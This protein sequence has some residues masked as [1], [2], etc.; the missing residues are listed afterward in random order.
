[1]DRLKQAALITKLLDHLREK[2]YGHTEAHIQIFVFFAQELMGIPFGF[3]FILY[4]GGPFSFDLRDELTSSVADGLIRFVP[5][6]VYRPS[7]IPT[8]LAKKLQNNYSNLF[9]DKIAYITDK[10][11]PK[12][13]ADLKRLA[14]ALFIAKRE[15][16]DK[17]EQIL[18]NDEK[19]NGPL[20][21]FP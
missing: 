21:S 17:S 3:D 11:G 14:T 2:G 16:A 18:N 1:M 9:E 15:G 13:I 4:K 8:E 7:F 19:E 12:G 10:F 6:P 20:K 5:N